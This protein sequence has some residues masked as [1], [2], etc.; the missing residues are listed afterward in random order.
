MGERSGRSILSWKDLGPMTLPHLLHL[1]A[2]AILAVL[3][4]GAALLFRQLGRWEGR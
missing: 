2:W 4:A 1:P 3:E